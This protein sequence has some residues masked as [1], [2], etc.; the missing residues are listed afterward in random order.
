MKEEDF[1]KK[2]IEN[3]PKNKIAKCFIYEYCEVNNIPLNKIK[4]HLIWKIGTTKLGH[5]YYFIS[6]IYLFSIE[7][8]FLETNYGP[9]DIPC[10]NG[11]KTLFTIEYE[12][13]GYYDRKKYPK[14][15]ALINS[16]KNKIL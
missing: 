10:E 13:S 2:M 5:R 7:L 8:L 3:S 16:L 9:V 15:A 6:N 4:Q 1:I 12:V 14:T 11:V